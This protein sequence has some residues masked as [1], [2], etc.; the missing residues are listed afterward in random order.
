VIERA[1]RAYR[2]TFSRSLAAHIVATAGGGYA[3]R[4]V[5]FRVGR[6]LAPGQA[7]ASGIYAVLDRRKG[8]ALRLSLIREAAEL[9]R[10]ESRDIAEGW[11]A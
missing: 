11:L 10:S 2:L 1:G 5:G 9:M 8:T 6:P 3:V 7:S 4:R